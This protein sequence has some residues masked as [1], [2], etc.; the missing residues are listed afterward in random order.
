VRVLIACE[1]SQEVCKAFRA[2]GHEAFSCDILPCS[3][4]HPEWH[5]QDD[6]LN[7]LVGW[8]LIIAHPPCTFL[9][10]AGAVRLC[11]GGKVNQERLSEGRKARKFFQ[12]MLDAPCPLVAVEN[13]TPLK[14]YELP[15]PS[16]VIQPYMFG[17]PFSKR[18][19]LW[20]RGLPPLKPTQIVSDFKPLL[21]SNTGGAKRGQKAGTGKER[22]RNPRE[23][24]KT[25]SG[26]AKA[27][28]EQWSEVMAGCSADSRGI[29]PKTEVLGILPNK[30]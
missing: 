29:P 23:S 5:I 17:H 7:H 27:M 19:L 10:K 11:R 4:G 26:V 25:F 1:E 12:Q 3:G 30:L 6:V 14:I 21:P 13:P 28:A 9:S 18:T 8:D 16:Q 2:R 15:Q 20:L 22:I 24:S